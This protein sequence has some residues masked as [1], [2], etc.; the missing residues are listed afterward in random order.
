VFSY[1]LGKFIQNLKFG[2]YLE[3]LSSYLESLQKK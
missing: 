3:R 1:L 2:K